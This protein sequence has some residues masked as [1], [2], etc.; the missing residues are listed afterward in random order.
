MLTGHSHL[1]PSELAPSTTDVESDALSCL[2]Y[3]ICGVIGILSAVSNAG[4]RHFGEHLS[5]DR[6]RSAGHHSSVERNFIGKF[7][8]GA[9]EII[10]IVVILHMLR[11]D[12][13]HNSDSGREFQE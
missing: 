12:V 5:D 1:H 10:E 11:I 3:L 4:A 6:M 8:K 9:P 2:G 7:H 13:G